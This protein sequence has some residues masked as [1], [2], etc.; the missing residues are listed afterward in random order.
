MTAF[1]R[2]L[3]RV[4]SGWVSRSSQAEPVTPDE[5]LTRYLF[6]SGKYKSS[7]GT[8]RPKAFLP[9][10]HMETSVFRTSG[11]SDP[12]I[13]R[14]GNKIRPT[15]AVARADVLASDVFDAKLTVVPETS[16]YENHAIITGWP[17]E[18]H[19]RLMRA[20]LLADAAKLYFPPAGKT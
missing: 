3:F 15:P 13:W 11:F 7:T 17:N 16:E 18:K 10:P 9:D 1:L 6:E 5:A 20:T 12:D 14:I 19:E 2:R 8:V 4:L